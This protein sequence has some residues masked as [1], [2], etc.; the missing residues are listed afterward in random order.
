MWGCFFMKR[1]FMLHASVFPTHVGVFLNPV[2]GGD[3]LFSLPHACGGVSSSQ[4]SVIDLGPSSPRMWGCFPGISLSVRQHRVFPTHVG[5]FRSKTD[6]D[7]RGIRLPH[8]CGGVS[9]VSR[10]RD[11]IM[12]SSPRMWGCFSDPWA[13]NQ[14]SS[15][16]PTHVGVFPWSRSAKR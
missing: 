11:I 12:E 4:K 13:K 9:K 2:K 15:V 6:E 10:I 7:P 8:A 5:V 14:P 3:E 1:Y 16:F